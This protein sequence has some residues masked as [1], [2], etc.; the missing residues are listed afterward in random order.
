MLCHF[1]LF[2]KLFICLLVRAVYSVWIF[3]L[4]INVGFSNSVSKRK[5]K[6]ILTVLVSRLY[7][8]FSA[9]RLEERL[10]SD[11]QRCEG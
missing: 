10:T 9:Q 2:F 11:A 3:A 7:P 6:D 8:T 1:S 5:S 4:T